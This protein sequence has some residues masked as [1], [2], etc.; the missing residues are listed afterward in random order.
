MSY[1]VI[2]GPSPSGGK[3]LGDCPVIGFEGP[4]EPGTRTV[5]RK[6][7]AKARAHRKHVRAQKRRARV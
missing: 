1:R 6:A 5:N 2:F 4:G 7:K 3:F